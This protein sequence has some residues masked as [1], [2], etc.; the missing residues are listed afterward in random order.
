[1][2]AD[3][4]EVCA[5]LRGL[6]AY[7]RH[8]ALVASMV[9]GDAHGVEVA[10]RDPQP[11]IKVA[12][13]GA[14]ARAGRLSGV[15]LDLS[16]MERRRIYR[17][18]RRLKAPATAD[19]LITR[20]RAE[21]GD[22]EAAAVLPACSAPVVRSLLPELEHAA[23]IGALMRRHPGLVLER[24]E[25]RLAAATPEVR[26]RIWDE[27]GHAVL[28]GDPATVLD[29]LERYAPPT[30]LPG[31]LTAYGLLAAHDPGRVA[32]LLTAPDRAAWVGRATL[33]PALLR[34]LAVL[35]TDRLVPLARRVR[36]N[37]TMFAALLDEVPPARRG[38]LYDGALAEVNTA[39]RVPP[40]EVMEALPAAVRIREANRVLGLPNIREREDSV[41]YWSSF[42][43]W[44]EASAEMADAL[45]SG[46]AGERAQAYGLLVDAARRSR[47]PQVVAELVDRLGRLRNEQ[48]PVRS[49]AL[50]ALSSVARLL[51]AAAAAGL[52][53]LTTDAVEA[54]DGS[55]VTTSALSALAADTLQHHVDVPELREW[56]LL[57]I[58]LVGST[59]RA[60]VLRRFDVV[61]RRGQEV[62]VADRL[63]NWVEDAMERGRYGPLFALTAAL[64]KRAWRVPALQELLHRATGRQSPEP[65]AVRAVELWLDNPRGRDDRLEQVITADP[66]TVTIPVVWRATCTSRTDLLDRVLDHPP[67]GRFVSGHL[68]WVPGWPVHPE[69]W[70]PRQHAAYMRLQERVVADTAAGVRQ[71]AAAIRASAP[72]PAL[73]RELALRYVDSPTVVLA[74]AALG[75]L[76]W[77]D[78]P[79][80]ALPLLLDRSGDDRAR[81]ALYAAGRAVRFVAPSRLPAALHPVLLNPVAKVTSRKEAARLL[82]RYGPPQV[83]RALLDTYTN[84]QTHRDIRAAIVSAARQRLDAEASWT[85]LKTALRGSR[86]ERRAV[87]AASVSEVA[88]RYRARYAALITEA[89]HSA[90]REVRR[91]AFQQLPYW[92]HW[93]CDITELVVE[94]L[95]D[96]GEHPATIEI[97]QL[98]RALRGAGLDVAFDRLAQRDAVDS[99]PAGPGTDRPARRRIEALAQGA[100]I[101]A[102]ST[103]LDTSRSPVVT[104]AQQLAAQPAFTATATAMLVGQ[105]R[106]DNL[107]EI[108]DLCA[109]RPALAVRTAARI[110]A[111]LREL[112]NSIDATVLRPTILRLADRGDL[113]GGL[114]AIELTRPGAT[115]GWS[116]P[117]RDLLLHLRHHPDPDVR[118][119]AYTVDMT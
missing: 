16:A 71:Q 57:T 109:G 111:R 84:P 30:R 54:R 112:P 14:A 40:T 58:D 49:A 117:W 28:D 41:R 77:T 114:F 93:A 113:S 15:D 91:A 12:A 97:A 7:E 69:R 32:T 101:W 53:R 100:V 115:F 19:A 56:A 119:E 110:A 4:V 68:R 62:M 95:T 36:D 89:C 65:V 76:V 108:A 1:M 48:D 72:I 75:A 11:S 88:D 66:T 43:S 9:V 35:P 8:L 10:L 85:I 118:N 60:P 92:S 33:P 64:G 98:L 39:T 42:L 29:L 6:G 104:A 2:S 27:V 81:V 34:R 5:D 38:A 82:V 18:L 45:R 99:Q 21:Y 22:D 67:R 51:T 70:L 94:R 31:G 26:D 105:G 61:L 107:D 20:V 17:L 79:A 59:A 102:R 86:E 50:T 3:R 103:P 106:L 55:A 46:D 116:T 90:D 73:G 24:A 47:D 63:S 25:A 96:L 74:E 87:L 78:R 80:E 52:T 23:D 44:P 83:M 13:L 37:A